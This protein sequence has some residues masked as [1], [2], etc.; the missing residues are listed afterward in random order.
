[1]RSPTAGLRSIGGDRTEQE[2]KIGRRS[3]WGRFL[4]SRDGATA[5]EFALVAAPFFVTLY[6]IVQVSLLYYA[7]AMLETGVA[8]AA[9]MIRTGQAQSA[10]M[11]EN[12]IRTLVCD[13]VFGLINCSEGLVIDVRAF[14]SFED[15]AL[16]PPIGGDGELAPG[17]YNAG[18]GSE[19]VIFRVFYSYKLPIPDTVTGLSN[20]SGGRRLMAAS[21]AFRN[22][23]F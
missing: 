15:V 7:E 10:G 19:V 8:A 1:M 18:V 13:R 14:P 4:R 20:M 16:P 12:E 23:P 22:E 3:V 11:T 17:T 6:A 9:R 5:V 2:R 21:A